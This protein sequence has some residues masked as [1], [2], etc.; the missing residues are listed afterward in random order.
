MNWNTSVQGSEQYP[1]VRKWP[2]QSGEF[3]T[4]ADAHR[5][6]VYW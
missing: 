6:S 3:F 2:V 4:D 5:C 1:D